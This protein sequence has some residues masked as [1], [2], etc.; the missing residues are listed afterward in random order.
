MLKLR[1]SAVSTSDGGGSA[2]RSE[3]AENTGKLFFLSGGTEGGD[4]DGRVG[5]MVGRGMGMESK[6]SEDSMKGKGK[7]RAIG[8]I[9][10]DWW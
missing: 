2:E 10:V 6:G 5:S 1:Q 8:E 9:A 3:K 4:G 7:R